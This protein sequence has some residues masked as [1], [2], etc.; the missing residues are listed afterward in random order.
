MKQKQNNR[1][2]K[3]S[4]E[5]TRVKLKI[6]LLKLS[7]QRLHNKKFNHFHTLSAVEESKRQN[8]YYPFTIFLES[9]F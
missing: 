6:H 1:A 5:L 4:T 9:Q 3:S 2:L 8:M 7:F